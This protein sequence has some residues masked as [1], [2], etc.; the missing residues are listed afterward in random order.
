MLPLILQIAGGDDPSGL[1][2]L[3][4]MTFP[5]LTFAAGIWLMV[6]VTGFFL[7][8]VRPDEKQTRVWLEEDKEEPEAPEMSPETRRKINQWHRP[9]EPRVPRQWTE[10]R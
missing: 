6:L 5:L 9:F 10:R 4:T 8:R 7:K 2:V 3:L 1:E